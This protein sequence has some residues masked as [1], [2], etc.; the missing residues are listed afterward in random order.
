MDD[1]RS[2]L[3]KIFFIVMRLVVTFRGLGFFGL[4][5]FEFGFYEFGFLEFGS[6][7]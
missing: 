1:I 7:I 5:F 6:W 3:S 2:T 4:R